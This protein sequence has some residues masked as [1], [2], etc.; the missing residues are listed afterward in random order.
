MEEYRIDTVGQFN[1]LFGFQTE[2][3]LVSVGRFDKTEPVRE[4]IYHYGLYALYLKENKGC[5]LS[6]GR[7]RYDFDE[8]TVTSFAP[9]QSVKVEANPD[10]P[11]ARWTAI[12]FHPDFIVRTSLGREISKYVFFSYDSNEALH[13]SASE[14]EVLR[15]VVAIIRQELSHAIDRHSRRIVVNNIEMLL[16]YCM[17]FYERQFVTREEINHSTVGLFESLL[18]QYMSEDAERMGLP[19]VSYFARSFNLSPGYFGELVKAETGRTAQDFIAERVLASA[20]ELLNDMSLTVTQVSE[21]LG[22][23]YPQHFIRFF[24]RHTGRTPAQYRCA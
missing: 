14:V 20:K 7:T 18:Q 1:D 17:R 3:P 4:G 9:G 5:R 24:K 23:E 15:S 11:F 19:A 6:Y 8:M 13:L 22:F 2:H 10:Q 21:R 16:N 12:V